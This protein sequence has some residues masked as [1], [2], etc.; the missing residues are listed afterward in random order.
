[1]PTSPEI[2][3]AP[4]KNYLRHIR[5]LAQEKVAHSETF[6]RERALLYKETGDLSYA[7]ATAFRL[8]ADAAV[9][10]K[11][12]GLN[13]ADRALLRVTGQLGVMAEAR[14][15]LGEIYADDGFYPNYQERQLAKHLKET[16]VIPFNHALKDIIN[17]H[18]N[19]EFNKITSALA[20]AHNMIFSSHASFRPGELIHAQK[21]SP[22]DVARGIEDCL[23]G[24]R[25]EVAAESM[26][27]AADID[28]DYDVS[29]EED[30]AGVDIFVFRD[31]NREGVDLKASRTSAIRAQDRHPLSRAV[32]SGLNPTDFTGQK[33][34]GR[35]TLSIPFSVAEAKSVAFVAEIDAM[36]E[37]N[38]RTRGIMS[39][40]ASSHALSNA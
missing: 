33:G 40:R 14:Q 1:M 5:D 7:T 26:F 34:T 11:E 6:Q 9:E 30:A 19:E 10:D 20:G 32:W 29:P 16:Y 8:A 4:E 17:T 13:Q 36:V 23:N 27:A 15:E 37:R 3:K 35:N 2:Q 28:Y 18:P 12:N 38:Y 39:Q 21:P 31:G 22:V 24:M 25:H